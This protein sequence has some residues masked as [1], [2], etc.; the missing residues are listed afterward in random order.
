MKSKKLHLL[1]I[2]LAGAGLIAGVT[3]F[4]VKDN[5]KAVNR[6]YWA[7]GLFAASY[8]LELYNKKRIP[9]TK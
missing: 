1:T 6:R 7:L 3:S 2:G 5:E 4:F 8:G 9:T